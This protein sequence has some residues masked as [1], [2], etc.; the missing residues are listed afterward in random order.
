MTKIGASDMSNVA[1]SHGSMVPIAGTVAVWRS[2]AAVTGR[3]C[4]AFITVAQHITDTPYRMDAGH[5]PDALEMLAQPL[6]EDFW[7]IRVRRREAV[8]VAFENI[9][10]NDAAPAADQP[11]DY[12]QFVFG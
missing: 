4:L 1:A 10:E 9:L 7:R 5:R 6:H 2:L 12:H 8:E 3:S 11:L